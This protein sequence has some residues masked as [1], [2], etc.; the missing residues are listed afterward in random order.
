M[1]LQSNNSNHMLD[2]HQAYFDAGMTKPV[3]FRVIHLEI[4]KTTIKKYEEE[5]IEHYTKI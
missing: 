4:L 3:A 5:V 1:K 2:E